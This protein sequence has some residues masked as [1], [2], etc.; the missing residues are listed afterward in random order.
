M[1]TA[2]TTGSPAA[3]ISPHSRSNQRP[4]LLFISTHHVPPC[5]FVER[6]LLSFSKSWCTRALVIV[7]HLCTNFIISFFSLLPPS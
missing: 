4:H 7:S 5:I 6:A 3:A 2:V 1:H